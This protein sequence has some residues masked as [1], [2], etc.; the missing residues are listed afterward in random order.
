[1]EAV[2]FCEYENKGGEHF[3]MGLFAGQN[4]KEIKEI[5]KRLGYSYQVYVDASY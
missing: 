5:I 1:V 3:H 2:Y 4:G